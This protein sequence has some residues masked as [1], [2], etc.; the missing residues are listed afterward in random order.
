MSGVQPLG[1]EVQDESMGQRHGFCGIAA[2]LTCKRR[3]NV[4]QCWKSGCYI[5]FAIDSCTTSND[6]AQIHRISFNWH[7]ISALL[8]WLLRFR[9]S[10][11][12]QAVAWVLYGIRIPVYFRVDCRHVRAT[13]EDKRNSAKTCKRSAD[14]G[15]DKSPVN[16]DGLH[17]TMQHMMDGL[18]CMGWLDAFS[19]SEP[20]LG[21]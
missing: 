13:N 20:W 21:W 19:S 4:W 3:S 9:R 16:W 8:L 12:V 17:L 6:H 7:S 10:A 15:F 11:G 1:C 5:I 18:S 14:S 2:R